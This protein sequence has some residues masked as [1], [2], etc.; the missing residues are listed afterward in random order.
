ME[1]GGNKKNIQNAGSMKYTRIFSVFTPPQ[2]LTAVSRIC[3]EL[4]I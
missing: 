2:A 1:A 3:R 4:G